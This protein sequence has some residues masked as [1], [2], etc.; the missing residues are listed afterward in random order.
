MPPSTPSSDDA[1]ARMVLDT[2][3]DEA[4]IALGPAGTVTRWS[5]GAERLFGHP[6]ARSVGMD[7]SLLYTSEDR[8]MGAP[9]RELRD[10]EALGRV[11][12]EC[13]QLRASGERFYAEVATTALR[14]DD[15][16]LAGF[17]RQTRDVTARLR[18]EETLRRSEERF[19]GIVTLASEAIVSVDEEQRIVLFNRGAEQVF[20]YTEG[21]IL[22]E[23]LDRLVPERLRGAHAAHVRAF[24]AT[25]ESA[26]VMGARSEVLGVRRNGEEFPAEATIS[27]MV[28]G[29]GNRLYTVVLRDASARHAAERE[30]QRLLEAERRARGDAE[31]AL[32]AR[33][34]LLRVVAHDFGNALTAVG[35]HAFELAGALEPGRL[36][37]ARERAA[38][39]L[40][41]V[42][43]LGRLQRDLVDSA[44]LEAG[45]LGLH[46]RE[47][48]AG[49]LLRRA[50]A[51]FEESA[52]SRRVE[53][54]VR[55]PREPARAV[56]DPDRLLQV[57]G[58][59][60][61]N[62]IRHS[63]P[64]GAVT[65]AAGAGEGG[66]AVSVED[67][68]PGIAPEHLP[69]LFEPFWKAGPGAGSGLGLAIARGIVEAHGG[70]LAAANRDG[71]GAR[72]AFTLPATAGPGGA[73]EAAGSAA[74]PASGTPVP[75]PHT[76]A[77]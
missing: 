5:A 2:V 59:L 1:L 29:A 73:P 49:D 63:P 56:A 19:H 21:E 38:V 58:N 66:V 37:E 47:V 3:R 44:A 71:P 27:A 40:R 61:S 57:V 60:V 43:H 36:E 68:G 48:D 46:P 51:A 41:M 13:W 52:R 31:A 75:P 55:A 30:I 7:L 34:E 69:H 50:A 72:F 70:A 53:L 67:E 11:E 26:R 10:A 62:A 77:V 16:R 54:R 20:G 23:P 65:L 42:E 18:H 12:R 28:D 24:A 74:S 39:I 32:R 9:R 45:R 6:A 17:A 8:S 76:A 64:G 22:G 14:R 33:G 25:G 35:F 15:G 4:L